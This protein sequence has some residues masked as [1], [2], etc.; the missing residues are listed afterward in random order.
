M[1][2]YEFPKATVLEDG[3]IRLLIT[4]YEASPFLREST[5]IIYI[6]KESV[7]YEKYLLPKK[8]GSPYGFNRVH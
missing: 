2:V 7:E 8:E 4:R 3:T 1:S 5:R 6:D